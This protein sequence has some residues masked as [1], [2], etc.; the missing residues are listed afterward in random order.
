MKGKSYTS[1][2][3]MVRTACTEPQCL[4]KGALYLFTLPLYI[5]WTPY[6]WRYYYYYYY[7]IKCINYQESKM[8]ESSVT[9]KTHELWGLWKKISV[10]QKSTRPETVRSTRWNEYQEY[11]LGGKGCRC[12]GLTALPPSCADCIEILG[13][14]T[15]GA[16][17]VCPNLYRIAVPLY[18]YN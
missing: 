16:Q 12:V 10:W 8:K 7:C 13:A 14:L 2:P 17:K 18:L 1:T 6:D 15:P 4:Y 11:S 9:N 3:P 5:S